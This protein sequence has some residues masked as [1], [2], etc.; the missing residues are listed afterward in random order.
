M[1][2]AN[3]GIE[4]EQRQPRKYVPVRIDTS[5]VEA[6]NALGNQFG[7]NISEY[8]RTAVNERLERDMEK[9]KAKALY[10]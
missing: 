5:A 6:I 4:V 10:A 8:V 3:Y 7:F 1:I 2:A 9:L